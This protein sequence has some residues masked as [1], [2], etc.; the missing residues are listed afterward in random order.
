MTTNLPVDFN[1]TEK[2]WVKKGNYF[3]THAAAVE[4]SSD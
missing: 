1:K 3:A 2:E 4:M